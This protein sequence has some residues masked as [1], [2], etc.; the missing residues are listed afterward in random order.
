MRTWYLAHRHSQQTSKTMDPQS[1]VCGR[2]W[3]DIFSSKAYKII[4]TDPWRS[5]AIIYQVA[6]SELLVSEQDRCSWC[7]LILEATAAR[8]KTPTE[9]KLQ[10]QIFNPYTYKD[11]TTE[12]LGHGSTLCLVANDIEVELRLISRQEGLFPECITRCISKPEAVALASNRSDRAFQLAKESLHNCKCGHGGQGRNVIPSSQRPS[13]LVDLK[14]DAS[15]SARLVNCGTDLLSYLALSY[16]W[17]QKQQGLTFKH[18]LTDRMQALDEAD[19][20]PTV[21]DALEVTRR[22]GYQY[23]WIDALCIEQDSPADKLKELP[24]MPQIY[25]N[26]SLTIVAASAQQSSEGF[27]CDYPDLPQQS[28]IPLWTSQGDIAT[29]NIRPCKW[30]KTADPEPVSFRAWTFQE[31]FLSK[32]SLIYLR[33]GVEFRCEEAHKN[34]DDTLLMHLADRDFEAMR[35][36]KERVEDG[37]SAFDSWLTVFMAY[38]RRVAT[39]DEDLLIAISGV[40][41]RF[42]ERFNNARYIAGMWMDDSLAVQLTWCRD[43]FD[44]RYDRVSVAP[45]WSW[46][47]LKSSL[48]LEVSSLHRCYS[49]FQILG[50][51]SELLYPTLPFGPVKSAKL[52]V[53]GKLRKVWSETGASCE[54]GDSYFWLTLT[55]PTVPSADPTRL[56]TVLDVERFPDNVACFCLPTVATGRSRLNGLIVI[57]AAQPDTF[58]R[59]GSFQFGTE[60]DFADTVARQMTLV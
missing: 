12:A 44:L 39:Y 2:C 3:K 53:K 60:K 8:S 49:S 22:L 29:I 33:S 14:P 37:F 48:R 23:I 50:D 43:Q 7:V 32:R 31:Q 9:S 54:P 52:H 51:E 30:H 55:D 57:A 46:A 26:A 1:L 36:A 15:S 19:V 47:S 20:S 25:G 58:R 21:R 6:R 28:A 17:G 59:I 27:L 34:I 38:T 42:Q 45:S 40:A 24:R 5:Q 10:V 41:Q 13:R 11:L 56:L 18:N 16:C 35:A 4:C